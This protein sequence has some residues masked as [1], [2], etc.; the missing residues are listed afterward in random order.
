MIRAGRSDHR[1]MKKVPSTYWA[2]LFFLAAFTSCKKPATETVAGAPPEV[3]VT[4][5]VAT[6]AGARTGAVDSSTGWVYLPTA[7][8]GPPAMA[9]GRPSIVPDTF[10]VLVVGPAPP[11]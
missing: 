9:G 4:E 1:F 8:L 5:V 2:A 11:Q 7:E 6:Q 3:F 10:K